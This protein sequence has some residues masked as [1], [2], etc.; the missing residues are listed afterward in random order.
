MRVWAQRVWDHTSFCGFLVPQLANTRAHKD[1]NW[2]PHQSGC[3]GLTLVKCGGG[4][5]GGERKWGKERREGRW[6]DKQRWCEREDESGVW[7]ETESGAHAVF[8][9]FTLN[10]PLSL[11]EAVATLKKINL[12][13]PLC[14]VPWRP[15]GQSRSITPYPSFSPS[16]PSLLPLYSCVL[17]LLRSLSSSPSLSFTWRSQCSSHVGATACHECA[18]WIASWG[19]GHQ[20]H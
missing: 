9:L 17:S 18:W 3:N 10:R 14:P 8:S 1:P 12:L 5:W 16:L 4:V 20:T 19:C 11:A 6:A 2:Q 7:L 13:F 15:S